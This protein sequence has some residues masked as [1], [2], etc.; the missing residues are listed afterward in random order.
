MP[1]HPAKDA[2]GVRIDP[3]KVRYFRELRAFKRSDLAERAGITERAVRSYE[4]GARRPS[5]E[6][7][8]KLYIA[9]G[10]GPEDLLLSG[11]ARGHLI[12]KNVIQVDTTWEYD[13]G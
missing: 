8:R 13:D 11:W 5:T 7:F 2:R 6:S 10:C 12:D 9:L 1:R 3:D 4:S